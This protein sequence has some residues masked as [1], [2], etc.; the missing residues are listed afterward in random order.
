MLRIGLRREGD[1]DIADVMDGQ[2]SKEERWT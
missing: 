2:N 1:G